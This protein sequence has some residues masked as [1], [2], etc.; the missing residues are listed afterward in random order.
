LGMRTLLA[1]TRNTSTPD[2]LTE[3]MAPRVHR[4]VILVIGR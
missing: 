2:L 1:A 3:I 4:R